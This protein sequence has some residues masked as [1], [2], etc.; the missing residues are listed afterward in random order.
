VVMSSTEVIQ[1]AAALALQVK[2][3]MV[4]ASTANLCVGQ[5]CLQADL[6]MLVGADASSPDPKA[7]E[8]LSEAVA[9]T[10]EVHRLQ[11]VLPTASKV[12]DYSKKPVTQKRSSHTYL[13]IKILV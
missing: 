4:A 2:K 13:I 3:P 7:A 6:D 1:R 10:W 9:A 12:P 5:E 11:E 8:I